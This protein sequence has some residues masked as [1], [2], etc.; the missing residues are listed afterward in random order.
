ML[1]CTC[2][3]GG[4]HTTTG[5]RGGQADFLICRPCQ[6]TRPC[7]RKP[8]TSGAGSAIEC[9]EPLRVAPPAARSLLV[10]RRFLRRRTAG[11]SRSGLR[12]ASAGLRS[13]TGKPGAGDRP[14]HRAGDRRPA[15][16]RRNRDGRRARRRDGR[17]SRSQIRKP[18]PHRRG[19]RIRRRRPR[20][21]LLDG[22]VVSLGAARNRVT[23][24]RRSPAAERMASPNYFGDPERP[25]P[26][27]RDPV[28]E[29][30]F[31]HRHVPGDLVPRRR[32]PVRD[33]RSGA[34]ERDRRHRPLRAAK[35]FPGLAGT[36]QLSCGLS[37]PRTRPASRSRP[38]NVPRSSTPSS[39]W[40]LTRSPASSVRISP[41][42][43]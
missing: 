5:R 14:R 40:P 41:R 19:R 39:S 21:R 28:E 20:R 34:H 9:G 36:L 23:A 37:S 26:R 30:S 4:Q 2:V 27:G 32:A 35:Q 15:T 22:H 1:R 6:R 24:M 16:Q 33:R 43:S 29:R 12:A 42:S 8:T 10:G 25:D 13:R 7:S 3:G 17:R 38:P 18:R 31:P 11:V